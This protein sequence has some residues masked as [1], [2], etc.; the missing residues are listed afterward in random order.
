MAASGPRSAV[1]LVDATTY[2]TSRMNFE[3]HRAILSA[4]CCKTDQTILH[5]TNG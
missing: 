2:R 4:K 1:F 3:V 5:S